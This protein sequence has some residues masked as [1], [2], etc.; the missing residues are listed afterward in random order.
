[1]PFL[2]INFMKE[3][4]RHLNNCSAPICPQ[5]TNPNYNDE[6][7]WWVG[8]P[9]CKAQPYSLFQEQQVKLN[10]LYRKNKIKDMCFTV[11]ELE[12]VRFTKKGSII[13]K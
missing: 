10:T 6:V 4:N 2:I 9:I 7:V 13:T 3:N 11:S 12:K 8:E 1:M 5:D